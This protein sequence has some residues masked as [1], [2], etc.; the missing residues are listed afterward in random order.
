M[1]PLEGMSGTTCMCYIH[2]VCTYYVCMYVCMYVM[3]VQKVHIHGTH[4]IHDIEHGR[5]Y[6]KVHIHD[7]I[8]THTEHGP[9]KVERK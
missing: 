3:Y 7:I 1:V 4:D 8:Y 6:L 2:V 5:R 9:K